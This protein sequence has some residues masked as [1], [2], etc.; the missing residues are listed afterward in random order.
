[1]PTLE[2]LEH[3]MLELSLEGKEQPQ[4][5]YQSSIAPHTRVDVS[6]KMDP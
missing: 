6:C 2:I 1:M 5:Q 3:I 4:V